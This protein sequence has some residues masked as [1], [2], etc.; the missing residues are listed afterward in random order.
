MAWSVNN[1]MMMFVS[2]KKLTVGGRIFERFFLLFSKFQ[3]K[4]DCLRILT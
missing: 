3:I 1:M 4:M 2:E